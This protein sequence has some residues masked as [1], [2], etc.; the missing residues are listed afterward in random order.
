MSGGGEGGDSPAAAPEEERRAFGP[1]IAATIAAPDLEA[2]VAAYTAH[3]GYEI[4]A[5]GPVTI[6]LAE[7]WDLAGTT[8]MIYA[9]LGPVSGAAVYIRLVSAPE[10]PDYQPLRTHGWAS[11][12]LTVAD[13][14]GLADNLRDSPFT[15]IGEPHDLD[16][17]DAIRAM[18]VRGPCNEVLL[19]TQIG[20]Q[21][22]FD[23]PRA[24]VPVDQ[25]FVAILATADL[26]AACAFYAETFGA[27]A[28]DPVDTAIWTLNDAFGLDRT[29]P[30]RIATVD[31]PGQS[32]IEID[33]YP[34]GATERPT[35]AGHLPAGVSFASFA[36]PSLKPFEAQWLGRPVAFSDPPS[37]GRRSVMIRG[38]S[39]ELIELIEI[40]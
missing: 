10:N 9:V 22:E 37:R 30:Q 39:G 14:D 19:L 21:D 26:G 24:T 25:M 23:V 13:V 38:A 20:E 17:S 27:T 34:P 40:P 29:T 36:V 31:L 7:S 3:L 16:F 4:R 1:L 15:I 18:Q 33:Q 35:R 11:I 5:R 2:A 6:A 8:G 28:S 32:L 12:E